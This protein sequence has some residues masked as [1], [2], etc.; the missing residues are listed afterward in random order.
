MVIRFRIDLWTYRFS[1]F[2]KRL[3]FFIG[4]LELPGIQQAL[5]Q[6]ALVS[7]AS[8]PPFGDQGSSFLSHL[9]RQRKGP[10]TVQGNQELLNKT[11]GI[12]DSFGNRIIFSKQ[13]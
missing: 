5:D 8:F 10:G 4:W 1:F 6:Q 2:K 9:H 3:R 7:K 11:S 12:A 13:L